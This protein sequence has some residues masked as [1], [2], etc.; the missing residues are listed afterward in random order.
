MLMREQFIKAVESHLTGLIDKHKMNLEMILT[1]PVAVAEHP[2][3]IETFES[4][5]E[6]VAHYEDML[7]A[8]RHL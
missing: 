6:K 7:S 1:N 4:E 5:L 2:D 8:L 3:H